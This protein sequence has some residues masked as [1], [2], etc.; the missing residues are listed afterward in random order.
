MGRVGIR[1]VAERAGVSVAT[2][3]NVLNKPD[4]VAP[5]TVQ[6]VL[7]VMDEVGF[8]RNDLA[9]QLRTGGSRTLGLIVLNVANPFFAD[10]TH[11]CEAAAEDLGY[12]VVVGSS[13]Q[14]MRREERYLSLFEEQRVR[15]LV[16][17][18]LG[19]PTAEMRRLRDR[20]VPLVLFDVRGD[21]PG[22]C[23]VTMDGRHGG[24]LAVRHLIETGRTR[25][26]FLGGPLRQ[27]E[28]RW[29]GAMQACSEAAGVSLRHLDTRDQTMAEGRAAGAVLERTPAAER[30][31]AVFAANDL[32]ALGLLQSLVLSEHLSVPED[33]AVIGYDDIEYAASAVVPLT[34]IRQPV[35]RLAA[36]ALRLVLDEAQSG[37]EH[38]HENVLLRGELVVRGSTTAMRARPTRPRP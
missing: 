30:P 24:H 11:A 27:V 34:T 37:H 35:D 5:A 38:R 7:Q 29:I 22:V 21:D 3:S 9:R 25:I 10:L 31:D 4:R 16:V 6:K 28:D 13:D 36:E 17:A 18:P 2:V 26:A 1:D 32:L 12:T 15:G 14:L 23:S 19:G 20:G 8:V 33:V